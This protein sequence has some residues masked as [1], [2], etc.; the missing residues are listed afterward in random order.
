MTTAF[1]KRVHSLFSAL[2]CLGFVLRFAD[3]G[4]STDPS[5]DNAPLGN[6][7]EIKYIIII[8]QEN[9]SFDS[10]YGRFPGADGYA[11]C[12]ATVPQLDGRA[13]PP[14]SALICE[15]PSPLT[16]SPPGLDPQF[17]SVGGKL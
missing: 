11:N 6:L 1:D 15:T 3:E 14:Y 4:Y 8:Y 10:L 17:P 5:S 16:G 13:D 12:F 7:N 9:W 2:L